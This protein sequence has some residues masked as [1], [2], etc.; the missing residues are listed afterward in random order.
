MTIKTELEIN[1]DRTK[2]KIKNCV[3]AYIKLQSGDWKYQSKTDKEYS[4]CAIVSKS[5]AKEYKKQFP[6]NG[7]TEV[8]TVDFEDQYKIKPVFPGD[9]QFVIKLRANVSLKADV[10]KAGLLAGDNVP[11]EWPSRPKV[12]LPVDGG[13]K[14]VTMSI[15]VSN[16]SKGD[17]AFNIH[18][19]EGLGTFPKLSGILVKDLIEYE[20][21][22]KDT[23]F[24]NI[25]GGLKP[26]DGNPQQVPTDSDTPGAS[27]SDNNSNNYPEGFDESDLP[28]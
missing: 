9:E 14:D 4:V 1:N 2:G 24:G 20:Q 10:P 27:N 19:Y 12:F 22:R 11:Y 23:D 3:F 28:F 8:E 5:T 15:L 26:G 25:V 21:E 7:Y 6:K 16:G 18:T 17:V 13:V